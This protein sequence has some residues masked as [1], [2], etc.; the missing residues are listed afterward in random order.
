MSD[1]HDPRSWTWPLGKPESIGDPLEMGWL[2]CPHKND[3]GCEYHVRIHVQAFD[4]NLKQH[5][6]KTCPLRTRG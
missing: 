2:E 3:R 1:P 4:F 6:A 5:L